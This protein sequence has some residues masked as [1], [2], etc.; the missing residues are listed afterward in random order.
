MENAQ[1]LATA[2]KEISKMLHTAETAIKIRF[3]ESDPKTYSTAV[4]SS[5]SNLR[6]A[7]K[8]RQDMSL[9]MN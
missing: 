4:S 7:A 6:Q 8:Q 2:V 9:W 3:S 5:P 1:G